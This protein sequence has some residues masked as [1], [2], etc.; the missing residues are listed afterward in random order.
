M[1][2]INENENNSPIN[3]LRKTELIQIATDFSSQLNS[4][5]EIENDALEK[6]LK[7]A[8]VMSEEMSYVLELVDTM[9]MF[10][11]TPSMVINDPTILE[12]AEKLGITF[13]TREES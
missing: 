5:L 10:K 7:D 11:E 2:P 3:P 4:K 6:Q 8:G 12:L 13:R 1:T 9:L